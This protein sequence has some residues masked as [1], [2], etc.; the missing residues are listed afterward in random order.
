MLIQS[1]V[2]GN[3]SYDAQALATGDAGLPSNIKTHTVRKFSLTR[4]VFDPDMPSLTNIR[5]L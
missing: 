2:I 1:A 3:D 5:V 4:R